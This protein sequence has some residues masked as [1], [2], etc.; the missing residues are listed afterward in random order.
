MPAA[1]VLADIKELAQARHRAA[2][3]S[4]KKTTA[5]APWAG[6]ACLFLQEDCV[7]KTLLALGAAAALAASAGGASADPVTTT[8][9]FDGA[10]NEVT[11]TATG[12]NVSASFAGTACEPGL[13]TGYNGKSKPI[14]N[15]TG[16]TV[17]FNSDPNSYYLMLS[18]PYITGGTWIL[19]ST[20]DGATVTQT[21]GT[22]T[23]STGD[24]V[25]A[26]SAKS[27]TSFLR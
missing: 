7:R 5:S 9:T 11:L 23:V 26:R 21:T 17:H 24:E 8:I 18:A 10:C 2:C 1:H 4:G 6:V 19:Y 27:I 15:N 13:G 14:L 25:H 12:S 3:V 16:M 20:A 22:Y